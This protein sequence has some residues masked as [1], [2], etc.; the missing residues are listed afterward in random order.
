V[1][2]SQLDVLADALNVFEARRTVCESIS[3]W[4]DS[5]HDGALEAELEVTAAHLRA[6]MHAAASSHTLRMRSKPHMRVL[7]CPLV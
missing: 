6:R 3:A 2:R 1:P 7:P 5:A 4:E